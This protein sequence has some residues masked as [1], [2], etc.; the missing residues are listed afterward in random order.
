LL[1]VAELDAQRT[2]SEAEQSKRRERA[3]AARKVP[4]HLLERYEALL[5]R[6]RSP[7]AAAERGCCSGCHIRLPAML[8]HEIRSALRILV[9]PHCGRLL[10]DPG[11]LSGSTDDALATP[12]TGAR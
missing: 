6:G 1:L 10:Y 8:G 12:S 3:A 4:A 2:G 5:K 9:C 11:H 7:I